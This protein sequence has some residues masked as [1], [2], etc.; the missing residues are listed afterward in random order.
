MAE[1]PLDVKTLLT[2]VCSS[3][4]SIDTKIDIITY[5]LDRKSVRVDK[6]ERN[7]QLLPMECVLEII[8]AKNEDLEARRRWN[9]V[10][11]LGVTESTAM[12]RIDTYNEELLRSFFGDHL[13]GIFTV[14][15]AHSS[16]GT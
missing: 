10:R 2:E 14:E 5:R 6:H 15:R 1:E 8:K 13:T 7:E 12:G 11:I 16:L 9:N 3:L 4:R